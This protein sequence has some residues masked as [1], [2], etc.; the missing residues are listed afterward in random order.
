MSKVG[1]ALR[2]RDLG[3]SLVTDTSIPSQTTGVYERLIKGLPGCAR[4]PKR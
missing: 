3:K 1:P 2:D 4:D